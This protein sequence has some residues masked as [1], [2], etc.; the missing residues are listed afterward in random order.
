MSFQ[1]PSG[2]LVYST[3]FVL[4]SCE[5]E[6]EEDLFIFF[7]HYVFQDMHCHIVD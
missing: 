3:N 6:L 2:A 7:S 4:M 5:L 1:S